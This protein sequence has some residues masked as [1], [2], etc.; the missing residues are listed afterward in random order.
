VTAGGGGGRGAA[1]GGID[2]AVA[3]LGREPDNGA[4]PAHAMSVSV[5]AK[6]ANL[7]A[8]MLR[9]ETFKRESSQWRQAQHCR[10]TNRHYM[11]SQRRS[12]TCE[13]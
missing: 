6:A 1:G 10:R 2:A 11:S 8:C 3:V 7:A 4:V 9:D 13:T 12:E 5:A